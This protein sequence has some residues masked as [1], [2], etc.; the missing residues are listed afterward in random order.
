MLRS[1]D[2]V[3]EAANWALPSLYCADLLAPGI[4]V[5]ANQ[6]EVEQTER[7]LLEFDSATRRWYIRTMQD[8]YWTLETS[9]GI[10]AA[11]G[12]KSVPAGRGWGSWVVRDKRDERECLD[13]TAFE[14]SYLWHKACC[15]V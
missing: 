1:L 15:Q 10:Q 14:G 6:E 2:A 7:F 3:Y 5:T 13:E 8:R 9:G 11:A 12:K 4:D